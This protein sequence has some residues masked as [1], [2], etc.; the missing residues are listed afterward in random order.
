MTKF[1]KYFTGVKAKKAYDAETALSLAVTCDLAYKVKN[2]VL[3]IA[4]SW[5]YQEVSFID[6]KKG[7]D[8]D[9]QG[10]VMGNDSDIVCVFRGSESID[11]WFANFQAVRDPGPLNGTLAHEGFQDALF[12]AVIALTNAINA[13]GVKDRRIWITGHSLGG[14]LCSL[15][16]GMMIENGYSIYGIYT[17]ASPR[18]ADDIFATSLNRFME[19]G[20]HYRL[21]NDGDIVPHVPPEPFFSH[22]G[23][24]VL[25]E[26]NKRETSKSE[27]T[28]MR[29]RMF[30]V[31]MKM[32]GEPWE[33]G[34]NH[35]LHTESRG[36]IARL[37]R[38][39]A[40]QKKST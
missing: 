22:P 30:E 9:T 20:P 31:L 27:W 26:Y 21:V 13:V 29:K 35:R 14:A 36:Y 12:P 19:D 10:F 37:I 11:D 23:N 15:Y 24:R 39:V 6:V 8:I 16:A 34:N 1:A 2:T 33:I 40:R 32:T 3:R 38:D 4:R 18:P 17:F 28:R 5:N 7:R 25:L